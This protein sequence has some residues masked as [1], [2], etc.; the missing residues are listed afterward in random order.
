MAALYIDNFMFYTLWFRG[1][2]LQT[3]FETLSM[4]V[5]NIILKDL[6]KSRKLHKQNE[7]TSFKTKWRPETWCTHATFTPSGML[8]SQISGPTVCY[9]YIYLIVKK[10][11]N[12]RNDLAIFKW[13]VILNPHL[14]P[15]GS[16]FYKTYSHWYIPYRP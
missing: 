14:S 7:N 16:N 9:F 15:N 4:I 3:K 1:R 2:A 6:K 12:I 5:W 10:A 11:S 8:L 13:W